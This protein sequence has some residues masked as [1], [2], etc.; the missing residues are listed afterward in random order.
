MELISDTHTHTHTQLFGCSLC[1]CMPEDRCCA[2]SCSAQ[3]LQP[4][5]LSSPYDPSQTD[6]TTTRPHCSSTSQT[7]MR[8]HHLYIGVAEL[9]SKLKTRLICSPRGQRLTNAL[10]PRPTK[11]R[12]K[13]RTES[14]DGRCRNIR[15]RR[16]HTVSWWYSNPMEARRG[17]HARTWECERGRMPGSSPEEV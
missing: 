11:I 14:P 10:S 3:E 16:G 8:L 2:T 13:P 6:Q 5:P 15:T 4:P 7:S 9:D 17:L 12:A 1:F